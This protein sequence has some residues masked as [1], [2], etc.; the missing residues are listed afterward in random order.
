MTIF[1]NGSSGVLFNAG[2]RSPDNA[3][4]GERSFGRKVAEEVPSQ[5]DS[6]WW[7][8]LDCVDVKAPPRM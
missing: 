1:W 3:V 8:L 5:G 7:G 2:A 4:K 6:S